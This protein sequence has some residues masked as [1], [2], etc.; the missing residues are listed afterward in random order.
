[1]ARK[2][3]EENQ[4]L[5]RKLIEFEQ[6]LNQVRNFKRLPKI[7]IIKLKKSLKAKS[8]SPKLRSQDLKKRVTKK[9]KLR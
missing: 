2:F 7:F 4:E 9:R 1:M 5:R 8:K 6:N 3:F